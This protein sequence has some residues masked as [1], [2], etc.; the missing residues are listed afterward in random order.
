LTVARVT[1]PTRDSLAVTFDVPPELRDRFRFTQG[2]F[3]T[4]RAQIDGEEVRRSYSICAAPHDDE[5]RVAIKRV[6]G[7]RFSNWAHA[8]LV[9]GAAVE[10]APPDGRFHVPLDPANEKHYL[11]FAAG[12]GITPMLSLVKTTLAQEPKSSFTLVYGNRASSSVMFREELQDLKDRHLGRLVL[13][14][15]MSRE[16]QDVELF[17]GRIDRAKCDA[18][19]EGWIDAASVDTAFVCGPEEMMAAV[20]ASLTAHGLDPADVKTELFVAAPRTG[21]RPSARPADGAGGAC[22]AFAIVDGRRYAFDI[23]RGTETVL[24]AGLRQG[25]D[26]PY[27]C[28]GGVC[29]TCRVLLVEGEVDMDVHYALEDYE[30]AR[31]YVL[32]CQSYPVTDTVGVNVDDHG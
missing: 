16:P 29:S 25:V 1:H 8:A 31:G 11:G 24:D 9:P 15:I 22:R 6:A 5:L 27:S 2:Q 32:M 10:V 21:A 30:I 3:L 28:K 4:L 12:S 20:A 18:L 19:L 7:G 14:F 26:L 13:I 23:E 17:S